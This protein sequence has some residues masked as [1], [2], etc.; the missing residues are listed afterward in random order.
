MTPA[1]LKETR[2]SLRL[3]Q[4]DLARALGVAA[5]TV[6]RWEAGSRSIPPYLSL[7][8]TGIECGGWRTFKSVSQT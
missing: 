4:V 5:N 7:A 3:S 2:E 1:E 6:N 8:L